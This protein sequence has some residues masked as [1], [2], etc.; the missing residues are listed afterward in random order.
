M[1]DTPKPPTWLAR[2][3]EIVK[4]IATAIFTLALQLLS[5]WG[6]VDLRPAAPELVPEQQQKLDQAVKTAAEVREV[7]GLE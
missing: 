1:N 6:F 7:F 4:L 5:Q 3:P 2:Q